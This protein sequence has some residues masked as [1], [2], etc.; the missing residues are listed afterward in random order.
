MA[1]AWPAT[2]C[3]LIVVDVGDLPDKRVRTNGLFTRVAPIMVW[4]QCVLGSRCIATMASPWYRR[5][6]EAAGI[7]QLRLSLQS[8]RDRVRDFGETIPK[9]LRSLAACDATF[10]HVMTDHWRQIEAHPAR[11]PSVLGHVSTG[12]PI[13]TQEIHRRGLP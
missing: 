13:N 3:R 6:N 7:L 4:L 10:L 2:S 5:M 1:E 9:L 11:R 12:T 8:F